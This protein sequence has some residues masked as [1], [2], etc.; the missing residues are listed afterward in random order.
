M[1]MAVANVDLDLRPIKGEPIQLD[2][3]DLPLE[4]CR[5]RC[6]KVSGCYLTPPPRRR[7]IN[8]PPRQNSY[9]LL[10]PPQAKIFA[11]EGGENFLKGL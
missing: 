4:V 7:K 5:H 11:A 8:P 3:N 9:V 6:A 1:T 2:P 10:P